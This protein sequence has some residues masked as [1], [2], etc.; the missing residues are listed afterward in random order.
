[1]LEKEE[2]RN[3]VESG[4]ANVSFRG[5]E[6]SIKWITRGDSTKLN[7]MKRGKG[8]G[9]GE[10]LLTRTNGNSKGTLLRKGGVLGGKK[11]TKKSF[12]QITQH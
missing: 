6:K 10:R 9:I 4:K 1:L 3:K 5:L 7:K 12:R 8:L 11:K 2:D